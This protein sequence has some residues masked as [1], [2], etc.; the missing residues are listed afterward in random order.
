[1]DSPT[2]ETGLWIFAIAANLVAALRLYQLSLHVKY[3]FFFGYL[4]A[5]AL[6]SVLLF[7]LPFGS[8]GYFWAYVITAPTLWVF[9]FLV[10]KEIYALIFKDYKGIYTVTR[11]SMYA[12][13]VLSIALSI[14]SIVMT[15]SA[16]GGIGH[17]KYVLTIER[18]VVFSL[19][20][21]LP[22][23]LYFLSHYP[24]ELQRN[25]VVH[26]ILYSVLF[27][28]DAAVHV[29]NAL[30]TPGVRHFANVGSLAINGV[31][32]GAWSVLLTRQGEVRRVNVVQRQNPAND[33]R[34]LAELNAMNQTLLHVIRK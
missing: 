28:S 31:C 29:I 30:S 33:A 3:C 1:M 20:L 11:W 34:L 10:V 4:I 15:H 12:A 27:L 18:A 5:Q 13:S 2:I 22:M 23:A 8:P 17:L 25:A 21:F 9:Y 14:L 19:V 32:F 16:A 26:S 24:I 6:Q 7:F